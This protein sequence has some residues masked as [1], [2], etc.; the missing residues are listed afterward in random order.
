AHELLPVQRSITFELSP[1]RLHCATVCESRQK[2][3]LG[4]HTWGMQPVPTQTF[5]TGQG[6]GSEYCPT[7]GRQL[8]RRLSSV[9]AELVPVQPASVYRPARQLWLGA[10]GGWASQAVPWPLQSCTAPPGPQR[11]VP[12]VHDE[13]G[14]KVSALVQSLG[15]PALESLHEPKKKSRSPSRAKAT[16]RFISLSPLRS[17]VSI[18]QPPL[19]SARSPSWHL[20]S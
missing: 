2:R 5:P 6:T 17:V 3:W 13:L 4:E 7:C 8:C 19:I 11:S 15:P 18:W 12:G 9:H 16:G 14:G 20:I 1:R 10:R